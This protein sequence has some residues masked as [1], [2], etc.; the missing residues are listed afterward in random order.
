MRAGDPD[1]TAEEITMR[2][3]GGLVGK[4]SHKEREGITR[5]AI[6]C[7]ILEK[8]LDLT[9]KGAKSFQV[10]GTEIGFSRAHTDSWTRK[11]HDDKGLHL[12][13]SCRMYQRTERLVHRKRCN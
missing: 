3:G 9:C 6:S 12:A 7:W 2:C 1:V 10:R 4:A 5:E 13:S 11:G 8:V